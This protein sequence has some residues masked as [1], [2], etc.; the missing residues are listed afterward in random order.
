MQVDVSAERLALIKSVDS[1]SAAYR[2][3]FR[4]GNLIHCSS[5][6][7][8]MP[9][10]SFMKVARQRPLTLYVRREAAAAS[11]K[12]VT[13]SVNDASLGIAVGGSGSPQH[14]VVVNINPISAA[15]RSGLRRGDILFKTRS[16]PFT[17][18]EFVNMSK[19]RPLTIFFNT[20]RPGTEFMLAAN[21]N[22]REKVILIMQRSYSQE[23][24]DN[25]QGDLVQIVQSLTTKNKSK[26]GAWVK[27]LQSLVAAGAGASAETKYRKKLSDILS[28]TTKNSSATMKG[29]DEKFSYHEDRYVAPD[30]PLSYQFTYKQLVDKAKV[31]EGECVKNNLPT[32]ARHNFQVLYH[33]QVVERNVVLRA[34]VKKMEETGTMF[35]NVESFDRAAE[36][37]LSAVEN[38]VRVLQKQ[39]KVIEQED[40]PFSPFR[41]PSPQGSLDTELNQYI[42]ESRAARGNFVTPPFAACV[43]EALEVKASAPEGKASAPSAPLQDLETDEFM[44]FLG[45]LNMS[46]RAELFVSEHIDNIDLLCALDDEEMKDLGLKLGER[47]KVRRQS[48]ER[49]NRKS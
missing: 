35:E 44:D 22:A 12:T 4:A 37:A 6:G 33:L 24:I 40:P 11:Y 34:C 1:N 39:K 23:Q 5:R 9:F 49:A 16:Q 14:A 41:L 3:G 48:I 47:K 31:E 43:V 21:R 19:I 26:E 2:G 7:G 8:G 36:T 25:P 38:K 17:Q 28:L 10:D 13:F 15:A 29:Y 20:V 45:R 30:E 46:K 42:L 32:N 18:A 27:I